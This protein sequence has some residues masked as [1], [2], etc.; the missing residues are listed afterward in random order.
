M[1]KNARMKCEPRCKCCC[2]QIKASRRIMV[3]Y[4]CR[5]NEGHE[6]NELH[7]DDDRD[8][9]MEANVSLVAVADD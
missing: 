8:K 7:E 2:S 4:R 3:T 9:M 5:W 6:K 1:A